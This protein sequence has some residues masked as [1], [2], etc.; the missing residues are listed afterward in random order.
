M[1]SLVQFIAAAAVSLPVLATEAKAAD[2]VVVEDTPVPAAEPIAPEWTFAIDPLYGWLPGFDGD[3]QVFG[4][5]ASIDITAWDLIENLDALLHALDG[6]YEGAGEWRNQQFGLQYDIVYM[7]LG[8]SRQ[9][10]GDVVSGSLDMGFK[11]SMTT[12][13]GNY[14]FFQT[15]AAYADVI[16]GVR[17]TDVSVDLDLDLGPGFEASDGDT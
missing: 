14:R 1:K 12:L 11:M 2:M 3:T 13:A 6:F 8:G 5:N 4:Q 17:I 9:F 15:P 16:A 10:G 7:S